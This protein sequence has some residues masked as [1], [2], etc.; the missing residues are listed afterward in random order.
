MESA[1]EF[2]TR[3]IDGFADMDFTQRREAVQDAQ[4][5]T[6]MHTKST[7]KALFR[8]KPMAGAISEYGYKN[9]FGT[10]VNCYSLEQ[11]TTMRPLSSKPRTAMQEQATANLIECNRRNSPAYKAAML[12]KKMLCDNVTVLDTETTDIDGEVIQI[13]IVSARDSEVLYE[14]YVHSDAPIAQGAFEK[15]GIAHDDLIGAPSF[16]TVAKQ[17]SELLGSR[18]W[19]AFNRQ[20]DEAVL[21]NSIIGDAN[22]PHYKWLDNTAPCIMYALAVPVFGSTNRHGS[23]SLA[24]TLS[25]CELTFSG[26]AHNASVDAIATAQV[27]QC[28]AARE[29]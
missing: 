8:V 15:H 28:I 4:L 10:Y 23:I 17:I 5:Q 3:K 18:S 20:F 27:V 6:K 13:A 7:L 12:A 9:E 14:S 1:L 26:D 25:H 2:Y 29:E 22:A 19:T 11:C 21:R 16:D 24:T